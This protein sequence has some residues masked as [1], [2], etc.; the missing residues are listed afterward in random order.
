L[1]TFTFEPR[2]LFDKVDTAKPK[3]QKSLRAAGQFLADNEFGIA[4]VVVSTSM[5][6]DAAKDLVLTQARASVVRGYL[7]DNFGF[8]DAELKT[9]GVGKKN[10]TSEGEWGTLEIVIYPPDTDIPANSQSAK[11][12][13]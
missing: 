8:D 11:E 9:L 5:A 3:N 4:V 10:G 12:R 6:G 13:Q 2:L 1:K 7:V